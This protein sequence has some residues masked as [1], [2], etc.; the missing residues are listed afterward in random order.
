M[1]VAASQPIVRPS[2]FAI[3]FREV[4]L[5]LMREL[6]RSLRSAKGIVLGLMTVIGGVGTTLIGLYVQAKMYQSMGSQSGRMARRS[7]LE[8][9]YGKD[10][11][12]ALSPAPEVMLA[13]FSSTLTL[14]ALLAA[15]VGYD[16]IS[17]ELQYRA[18]RYS[19]VRARRDNFV[20]GKFLGAFCV[21]SLMTFTIHAISWILL[22]VQS[23]TPIDVTL[24]MGPKLW[25][26]TLPI[27]FA[28]CALVAFASSIVKTPILA[29]LA[30]IL[31]MLVTWMCYGVGRAFDK[32][33]WLSW[34][35]PGGYDRLLLDPDPMKLVQGLGASFAWAAVFIAGAIF[36]TT[37]RDV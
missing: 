3:F 12:E 35:H 33:E 14:S 5:V 13:M 19:T 6:F 24:G 4:G 34:V 28:W 17:S 10:I 20:I 23:D 18:V 15:F 9:A 29:L 7:G 22:I 32:Y 11:A 8:L 30:T 21:A 2:F 27:S 25:L 1:S 26:L 36:V 16:A 37:K 31:T